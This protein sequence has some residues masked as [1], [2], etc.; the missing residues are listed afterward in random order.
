MH[1]RWLGVSG[2][3]SYATIGFAPDPGLNIL[4]GRN[5]QGKT[6]LLEALHLVLTGRSFRTAHVAECV[7]WG[8]EVA[9]LRAEVT[10]GGQTR[11]VELRLPAHGGVESVMAPAPWAR[12]VSF[13]ASDLALLTGPP[14]GRRAYIDVVTAKLIPAHAETSR[15]YRLVLSQRNRLLGSLAGRA[16]GERLLAPWDD[17]VATLGSELTHRRLDTLAALAQEAG[18]V[19]RLLVP[20]GPGLA[21][22][23]APAQPPG[24]DRGAT[25]EAL[26]GGL[27]ARHRFDL[28]RGMT[29]VG[30]HRDD[31]VVRLG[32]ADARLYASRG[33]QRLLV[34]ALRLAEAASL[35]QRVGAPP[36]LLLDDLLSELD[37][38]VSARVIAWLAEQGQVVFST[39]DALPAGLG[40]GAVWDVRDGVVVTEGAVSAG[41]VTGRGA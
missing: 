3:R 20:A 37:R 18:T 41:S 16:D 2:F 19:W 17:Q 22:E 10:H 23:Y 36:V 31:L 1:V 12:A 15:R 26:L 28:A 32:A 34:L 7:A 30:P 9:T 29:S 33:E 27:Y 40:R 14:P 5:G 13:A 39:T 4:I 25:R 38:E 21:I 8:T 24:V 11:V 35:R 6:S